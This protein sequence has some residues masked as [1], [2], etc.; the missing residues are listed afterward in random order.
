MTRAKS[1]INIYLDKPYYVTGD[2]VDAIVILDVTKPIAIQDMIVTISGKESSY[3]PKGKYSCSS[4]STI[5]DHY[6]MILDG[7]NEFPIGRYC[8]PFYFELPKDI[9]GSFEMP[10]SKGNFIKYCLIVSS[11][12]L[13]KNASLYCYKEMIII[14]DLSM[15][16]SSVSTHSDNS[17]SKCCCFGSSGSIIVMIDLDKNACSS[18]EKIN[19]RVLI[20]NSSNINKIKG[21]RLKFLQH[22]LITA[23]GASRTLKTTYWK[24]KINLVV[25]GKKFEESYSFNI[26]GRLN[27]SCRGTLQNISYFFT[28]ELPT[29]WFRSKSIEAPVQ[30][31]SSSLAPSA[32]MFIEPYNIKSINQDTESFMRK[33][34]STMFQKI[35]TQNIIA[36]P[37]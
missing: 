33:L 19:A 35:A 9:P 8:F 21:I 36:Y 20:D 32:N 23:E 10:N 31:Y 24:T 4:S 6:I 25:P 13:S 11:K 22:Q 30:I 3:I 15:P 14:E 1:Q 17:I 12:V 18:G 28:V 37:K 34:D 26:P 7:R 27:S 5:L 29:T 2:V 16:I